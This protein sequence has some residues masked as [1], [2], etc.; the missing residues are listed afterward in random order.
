MMRAEG[1]L[2]DVLRFNPNLMISST[3]VQF[4]EDDGPMQL[5]D[6]LIHGR[7]RKPVT[8]CRLVK[9]SVVHAE[10]PQTILLVDKE[11]W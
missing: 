7:Y 11:N 4:G 3:E 5:V 6:Q 1:G 9:G 10:A 8:D 2:W